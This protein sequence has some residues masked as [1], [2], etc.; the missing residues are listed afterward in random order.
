[1][2]DQSFLKSY[3]LKKTTTKQSLLKCEGNV[4]KK[5]YYQKKGNAFVFMYIYNELRKHKSKSFNG[6]ILG[7]SVIVE[8]NNETHFQFVIKTF[9]FNVVPLLVNILAK[10]H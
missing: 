2:F 9:R 3:G 4:Q 5:P 6:K 1:M 7:T 8:Y 10:A